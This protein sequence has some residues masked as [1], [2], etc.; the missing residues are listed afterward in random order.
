MTMRTTLTLLATCFYLNIGA[1]T[2]DSLRVIPEPTDSTPSSQTLAKR[3]KLQADTSISP[4]PIV[5][6]S[7]VGFLTKNYPNPRVAAFV[8]MALPG[9]GQAYNKKWWKIP[10]AWGA[11]G[12]IAYG[13]FST[14]RTYRDLRDAYKI[15]VNGGEP[16]PPY[17][18]FDAPRLKGYRD[19]FKGYVEKW[20]LALGVTYLLVVTDA[21][22]DAHLA[23][24]D[25]DDNLSLRF[26]PSVEQAPGVPA[27]GFGFSIGLHRRNVRLPE[28]L[29][30]IGPFTPF[31]TAIARP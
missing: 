22:V 25:V 4:G 27:F 17:N 2:P 16:K 9:A 3:G 31:Q 8:S 1:Q 24:F 5:R 13:T 18:A 21:F 20:Y 6:R 29:P 10:I 11:L 7:A 23:R 28:N 15:T 12:G 26:K 19:Q 30:T 14:Q